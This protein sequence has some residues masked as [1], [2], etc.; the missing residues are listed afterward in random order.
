MKC[1]LFCMINDFLQLKN[2]IVSH[3]KNLKLFFKF[4]INF[5]SPQCDNTKSS[6]W[7][8]WAFKCRSRM[9]RRILAASSKLLDQGDGCKEFSERKTK[10]ENAATKVS[11]ACLHSSIDNWNSD[12]FYLSLCT[13]KNMKS[14]KKQFHHIEPEW[15]WQ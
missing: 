13:A 15:C 6:V 1:F 7:S 12:R 14:Q 4:S 9:L 8:I 5:S 10:A 11:S 2:F 3:M